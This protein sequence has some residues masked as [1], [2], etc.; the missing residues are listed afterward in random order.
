MVG[1]GRNTRPGPLVS[2]R[3]LSAAPWTA[4][5][6]ATASPSSPTGRLTSPRNQPS[7]A[8]WLAAPDVAGSRRP[9]GPASGCSGA[10]PAPS[11]P[12]SSRPGSGAASKPSPSA[13]S[14]HW[15]SGRARRGRSLWWRRSLW[16]P[17]ICAPGRWPKRPPRR[18]RRLRPN[19]RA[20]IRPTPRKSFTTTLCSPWSIRSGSFRRPLRRVGC[21]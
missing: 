16:R 8:T 19:R 3:C 11:Y 10:F 21:S 6:S 2:G 1:P 20:A 14:P 7:E 9:S 5:S 18:V 13:P 17:G 4:A 12:D 15:L